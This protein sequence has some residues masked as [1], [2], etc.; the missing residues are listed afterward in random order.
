MKAKIRISVHDGVRSRS[1]LE[2]VELEDTPENCWRQPYPAYRVPFS[3]YAA[4]RAVIGG[5]QVMLKPA[6]GGREAGEVWHRDLL[7]SALCT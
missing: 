3:E 7:S 4:G 1:R 6:R 2:G 5:G